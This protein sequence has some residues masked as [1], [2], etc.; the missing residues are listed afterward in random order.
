MEVPAF[1][2]SFHS[3]FRFLH[4]R[5][6]YASRLRGQGWS[7][8]WPWSVRRSRLFV[9]GVPP[10][11]LL[12]SLPPR[13]WSRLGI[14]G[15]A[16]SAVGGWA[17]PTLSAHRRSDARVVGRGKCEERMSQARIAASRSGMVFGMALVSS[18]QPSLVISRSSSMRMP[19][20][21]S[22]RYTPGSLLMIM[23]G[24]SGVV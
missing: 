16:S 10:P 3:S 13:A 11:R 18:S 4:S 12:R 19:K 24:L 14:V 22:G 2:G 8:G 17:A 7:S 21:S 20:P 1:R 6:S 15:F 9:W 5:I 23:P